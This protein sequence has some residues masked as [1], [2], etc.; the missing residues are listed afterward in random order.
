MF[1]LGPSSRTELLRGALASM[2]EGIEKLVSPWEECGKALRP[3]DRHRPDFRPRGRF[4]PL[5]V[6]RPVLQKGHEEFNPFRGRSDGE[7]RVRPQSILAG[8]CLAIRGRKAR[9]KPAD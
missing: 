9:H 3:G 5:L 4:G 2:S 1:E 7:L 6:I 8:P